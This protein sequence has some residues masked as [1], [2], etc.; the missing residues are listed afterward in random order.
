MITPE[1]VE[2]EGDE[3]TT[4]WVASIYLM[5]AGV[6]LNNVRRPNHWFTKEMAEGQLKDAQIKN[7][8]D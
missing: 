4:L 6:R 7:D 2:F 5:F 1:I 8:N 3:K